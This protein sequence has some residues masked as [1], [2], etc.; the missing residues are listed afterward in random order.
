VKKTRQN[1]RLEP[2]SD[3]IRTDKAPGI[4]EGARLIDRAGGAGEFSTLP[5]IIFAGR[6]AETEPGTQSTILHGMG[7]KS[8]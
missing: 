3:A 6:K 7:S 4:A 8:G 5:W 2:G 1:K